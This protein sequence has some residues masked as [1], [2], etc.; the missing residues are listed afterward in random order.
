MQKRVGRHIF[1]GLT[2]K[3]V[4]AIFI[5]V[6]LKKLPIAFMGILWKLEGSILQVSGITC[7]KEAY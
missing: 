4:D 6:H 3:Y 2:G 7:L 1:H 5:A